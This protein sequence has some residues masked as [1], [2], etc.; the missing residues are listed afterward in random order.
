MSKSD[1]AR[2]LY[3]MSFSIAEKASSLNELTGFELYEFLSE[4]DSIEEVIAD[5]LDI[6]EDI[7]RDFIRDNRSFDELMME[8]DDIMARKYNE[9]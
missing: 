1:N 5:L 7:V 6:H 3:D 4:L 9:Y 8:K 2:K